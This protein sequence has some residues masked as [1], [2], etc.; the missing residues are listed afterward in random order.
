MPDAYRTALSH[1][2]LKQPQTL[3]DNLN[4]KPQPGTLNP[5]ASFSNP[6]PPQ[7]KPKLSHDTKAPIAHESTLRWRQALNRGILHPEASKP[8]TPFL[9]IR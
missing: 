3:N 8:L 9:K 1:I 7:H 2:L 6:P 4:F 5:E